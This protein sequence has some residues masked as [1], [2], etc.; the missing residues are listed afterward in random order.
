MGSLP[1]LGLFGR[2][3]LYYIDIGKGVLAGTPY[4]TFGSYYPPATTLLFGLIA[5]LPGV[6]AYFAWVLVNLAM[7]VHLF[8]GRRALAWVGF[9]PFLHMVVN[10]N[11]DFMLVWVAQWLGRR[12][13]KSVAAA[14][15][16][17]LKPQLAFIILPYWLVK[18]AR[19]NRPKFVRFG[20]LAAVLHLSPLL[21]RP[22]ILSEWVAAVR[23]YGANADNT[24]VPSIFAVSHARPDL[25][26]LMALAA[27]LIIAAVLLSARS[28]ERFAR[29]GMAL[30]LPAGHTYDLVALMDTAPAWLLV[31]LSWIAAWLGPYTGSLS[32]LALPLAAIAYRLINRWLVDRRWQAYLED[33]AI[34]WNQGGVW[35]PDHYA[36]GIDRGSEY[37][38]FCL[39][40]K[41]E[42]G[43]VEVMDAWTRPS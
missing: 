8:R 29:A 27:G 11:L 28:D 26:W 16:L 42:D 10:G 30:C 24:E 31:P 7:L 34:H 43:G 3:L 12:D 37:T 14:L 1:F 39:V 6:P 9:F 25:G 5:W 41:T 13:W 22:T 38:A 40:R 23:S 15:A 19:T 21:V 33:S 36:L 18:W 4:A 20:V 32:F 17:T 35:P 2:D